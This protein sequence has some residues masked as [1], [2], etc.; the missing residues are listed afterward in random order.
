MKSNPYTLICECIDDKIPGGLAA[1]KGITKKDVDAG[2]LQKGIEVELEHTPNRDI[3]G[4]IA[5]DHLA[6]D[7]RYYSKLQKIDPHHD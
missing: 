3:A 4:E 2:E 7:P 5:L 6:E 1:E